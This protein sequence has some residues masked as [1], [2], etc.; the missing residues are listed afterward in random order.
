MIPESRV[1]EIRPIELRAIARRLVK[2]CGATE[3]TDELAAAGWGRED[4]RELVLAV[5]DAYN[6]V[7]APR[8][9][10]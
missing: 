8:R 9:R 4:A 10:Y 6:R 3:F 7:A 5:S 1:F 2:H